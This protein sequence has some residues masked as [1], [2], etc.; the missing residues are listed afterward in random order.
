MGCHTW[1]RK[2][3]A[4]GADNVKKYLLQE[5]ET[6]R[7]KDWWNEECEAEVPIRIQ[8]IENMSED[9]DE[10]LQEYLGINYYVTFIDG[11]PIIF[12]SYENDNDE[13]RIGGYPDTIIRSA[14]QMFKA[15]ETGLT[16]WEGK[17]FHFRWEKEREDHI[18][19]HI[20]TFFQKYPDGIIEFG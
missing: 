15:M 10:N 11:E 4:K 2:P 8:A 20:I 19:N 16:N 14:D 18:K 5:I 12:T 3:L 17:H 13:P 6:C 1:F 9:M 7:Q